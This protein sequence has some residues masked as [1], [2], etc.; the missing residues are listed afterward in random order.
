LFQAGEM[1]GPMLVSIHNI[2]YYQRLLAEGR[3]AIAE[4]RFATLLAERQRD[5]MPTQDGSAV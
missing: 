2:T 4:N 3:A 5:W 1:L